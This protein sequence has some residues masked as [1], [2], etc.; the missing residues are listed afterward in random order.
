MSFSNTKL[1]EFRGRDVLGAIENYNVFLWEKSKR[2]ELEPVLEE[3]NV[4]A[5]CTEEDG[6]L[7][8]LV[9]LT[10]FSWPDGGKLKFKDSAATND[11]S[12]IVFR[13]KEKSRTCLFVPTNI[14]PK[15]EVYKGIIIKYS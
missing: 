7:S 15:A 14:N 9:D 8:G 2:S 5:T 13:K 1:S 3:I 4:F 6:V 12:L 11:T 10:T